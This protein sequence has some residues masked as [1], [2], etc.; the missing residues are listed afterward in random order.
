VRSSDRPGDQLRSRAESLRNAVGGTG[1]SL[2]TV[3]IDIPF[4]VLEAVEAATGRAAL[5]LP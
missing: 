2:P 5:Y 3:A 4:G 1:T